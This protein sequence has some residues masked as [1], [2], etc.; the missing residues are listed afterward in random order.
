MPSVE[1]RRIIHARDM[2]EAQSDFDL[3][4]GSLAKL[5]NQPVE[6]GK[7]IWE[8][9]MVREAAELKVYK[10]P[11][12]PAFLSMLRAEYQVGLV[13]AQELLKRLKAAQP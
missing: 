7:E 5:K 10:G 11:E 4:E 3:F 12:D 2:K 13:E 6:Y 1:Y 8:H 9:R